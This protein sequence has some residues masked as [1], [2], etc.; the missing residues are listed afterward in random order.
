MTGK[1]TRIFLTRGFGFLKGEDGIERFVHIS[2]VRP[3]S[4]EKL[5]AGLDVEFEPGEGKKGPRA[6]KVK[7]HG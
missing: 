7:E 2:E 4:W 1:I 6:F 5:R 3:G